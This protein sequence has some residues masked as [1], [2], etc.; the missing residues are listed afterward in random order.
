MALAFFV[1]V[2]V[3]H[4]LTVEHQGCIKSFI[5]DFCLGP[6]S[7]TAVSAT[8]KVINKLIY[9]SNKYYMCPP[10]CFCEH[11]CRKNYIAV[12]SLW[13]A[14]D[15]HNTRS[16]STCCQQLIVQVVVF[17]DQIF[18]FCSLIK[19]LLNA[20][21]FFHKVVQLRKC[22]NLNIPRRKSNRSDHLPVVLGEKL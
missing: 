16:T 15:S 14:R 20:R 18:A 8:R 6:V 11:A 4:R 5:A 19:V 21:F 7:K 3:I 10:L 12:C 22:I 1:G 17:Q 2:H 9:F 13:F